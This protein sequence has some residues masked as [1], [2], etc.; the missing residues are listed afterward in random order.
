MSTLA[1]WRPLCA[2]ALVALV[3]AGCGSTTPSAERGD[4][5]RAGLD[6]GGS[7]RDASSPAN[8]ASG[9]ATATGGAGVGAGST[10]GGTGGVGGGGAAASGGGGTGPA[11]GTAS[12]KATP[13]GAI[14][15][16]V[17]MMSYGTVGAQFG[18]KGLS[19]GVTK[20]QAQAV[21]N[22]LNANGGIA[23]RRIDPVYVVSDITNGTY[24][25]Q[26]QTICTTLTE[27]T[28]VAVVIGSGVDV[29]SLAACLASHHTP[30][31]PS[32]WLPSSS[33]FMDNQQVQ[34]YEP[35]LYL[36]NLLDPRRHDLAVDRWVETKFLT[37]RNKIAL[38]RADQPAFDRITNATI[39]PRLA[40]HGLKLTDEVAIPVNNS[41]SDISGP[42]AQASNAVLRFRSEGIDRVL[43][44]ASTGGQAFF[45]MP[46]AEN[47]NYHPRY[48]LTTFEQPYFLQSNESPNQLAGAEGIGWQPTID[49]DQPHDPGPTPGRAACAD[50]MK[51]AGVTFADRGVENAAY[52]V[53]ESFFL[54]RDAL[55]GA[56]D[57]TPAALQRGVYR[58]G[59]GFSP[60][61]TL[62]THFGPGRQGPVTAVRPIHFD[63]GCACFVY[64]GPVIRV[65]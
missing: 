28:P 40:S 7:P 11:G 16:G 6:L 8:G 34:R 54:V 20:A 63:T 12:P 13:A 19:Q 29:D 17:V 64:T 3:A 36:P 62:G 51:R 39:K 56:T 23:G 59:A 9:G 61:L 53:C 47:Q 55:S 57:V 41:V 43:L 35:Y 24:S 65:D 5:G 31:I 25:G 32:P 37:S 18:V 38:L 30:F 22:A 14:K 58:L 44:L 21:V 33:A 26:A 1:R 46:Q 49:T 15:V 2:I 10:A 4:A 42:A 50:I 27:D 52:S 60:V 45:F 48:G